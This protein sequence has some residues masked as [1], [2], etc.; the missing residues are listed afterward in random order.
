[1]KLFRKMDQKNKNRLNHFNFFSQKNDHLF[2]LN[3]FA[4]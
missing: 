4:L 3:S 1:M 2:I